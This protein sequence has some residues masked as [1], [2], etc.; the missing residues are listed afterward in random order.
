MTEHKSNIMED[1]EQRIYG[2]DVD[3]EDSFSFTTFNDFPPLFD[4]IHS[5]S[6]HTNDREFNSFNPNV[7]AVQ[8]DILSVATHEIN[9]HEGDIT[10]QPLL[11]LKAVIPVSTA[12]QNSAQSHEIP[13]NDGNNEG[14]DDLLDFSSLTESE[15][16][17]MWDII[18]ELKVLDSPSHPGDH[19]LDEE[20]EETNQIT[21]EKE[22][23]VVDT[24]QS[25]EE[26]SPAS[27]QAVVLQPFNASSANCPNDNQ[28]LIKEGK[29]SPDPSGEAQK[30]VQKYDNPPKC[31]KRGR[32]SLEEE[33]L[34][35]EEIKRRRLDQNR[36]SQQRKRDRKKLSKLIS[37]TLPSN[38]SL[39]SK[40]R[41]INEAKLVLLLTLLEKL[42]DRKFDGSLKTHLQFLIDLVKELPF[43]ES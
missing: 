12:E 14:I 42:R 6:C 40:S 37:S 39:K 8:W 22:Q 10:S 11:A 15:C 19:N 20:N 21:I 17:Q 5:H 25:V 18:A 2:S 32:R 1:F 33:G 4:D 3:P 36:N 24:E 29:P 16:Q 27:Q 35:Q 9:K 26:I 43:I 38:L 28:I 7:K 13:Q 23:N 41:V 31:R 34:T 30:R